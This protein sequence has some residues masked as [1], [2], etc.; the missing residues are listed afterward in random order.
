MASKDRPKIDARTLAELETI[1]DRTKA[2]L[3]PSEHQ[4]LRTAVETLAFVT[5]EIE[6]KWHDPENGSTLYESCSC[7]WSCFG[8]VGH[9]T[10]ELFA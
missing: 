9:P 4:T 5:R 10:S 8:D 6:S 7:F 3:S 1:V 2:A